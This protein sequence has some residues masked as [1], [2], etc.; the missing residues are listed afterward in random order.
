[1]HLLFKKVLNFSVPQGLIGN[2]RDLSINGQGFGDTPG[3][4]TPCL[5]PV[6]AKELF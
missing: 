2:F 6:Q 3:A 5:L 1:M 4:V